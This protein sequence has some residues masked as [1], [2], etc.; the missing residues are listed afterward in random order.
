MPSCGVPSL[1][2]GANSAARVCSVGD[3]TRSEPHGSTAAVLV[4]GRE[5]GDP[6]R[7]LGELE[8][9]V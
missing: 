2:F 5:H 6:E 9:L 4:F 7:A 1:A 3:A 8:G